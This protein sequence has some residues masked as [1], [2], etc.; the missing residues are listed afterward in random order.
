MKMFTSL[1]TAGRVFGGALLLILICF[2]W[3]GSETVMTRYGMETKT[4]LRTALAEQTE[5]VR[6]A[7]KINKDNAATIKSLRDDNR[8]LVH[9]LSELKRKDEHVAKIVTKTQT[10]LKKKIEPIKAQ[11]SK[12]KV[13]SDNVITLPVA[14]INAKSEANIT[15]LHDTYDKLFGDI[16]DEATVSIATS[17]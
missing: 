5:A 2:L 15:A 8:N 11:I 7:V 6:T 14:E 4:S 12:K 17:T 9:E 13:V 1:F 3:N 16:G 10:D